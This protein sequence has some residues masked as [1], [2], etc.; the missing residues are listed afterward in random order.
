MFSRQI[1]YRRHDRHL[2]R[3]APLPLAFSTSWAL[4]RL[5]SRASILPD[6][7]RQLLNIAEPTP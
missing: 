6:V 4:M 5:A 7:L 2:I 1:F 3:E